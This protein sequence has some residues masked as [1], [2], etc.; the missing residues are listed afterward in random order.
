VNEARDPS[1][2]LWE[3]LG[4]RKFE[5]FFRILFTTIIALALLLI[6]AVINLFA[7]DADE[8]I[9]AFSPQVECVDSASITAE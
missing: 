6:T 4:T 5:R 3:N 7:A 1:L 8:R 2:I 9:Q